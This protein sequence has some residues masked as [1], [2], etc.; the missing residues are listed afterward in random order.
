MC[1]YAFISIQISS[2]V[3][4][5]VSIVLH[6]FVIPDLPAELLGSLVFMSAD[7]IY[8]SVLKPFKNQSIAARIF[9]DQIACD[10]DQHAALLRAYSA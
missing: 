4:D 9:I 5:I 1:V 2:T 3:S 10:L 7:L 8:F 6:V